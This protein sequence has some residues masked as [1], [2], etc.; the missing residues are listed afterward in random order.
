MLGQL[1]TGA[2]RV[3]DRSPASRSGRRDAAKLIGAPKGDRPDV[4]DGVTN[5]L[6]TNVC[7]WRIM[8]KKSFL[9]DE[10]IFLGPLVRCSCGDVRDHIGSH[11]NDHRPS[12]RSY[13]ALQRRRLLKSDIREI[14]GVARFSTF[15][16]VSAQSGHSLKRRRQLSARTRPLVRPGPAGISVVAT[17]NGYPRD[18]CFSAVVL[19]LLVPASR[20]TISHTNRQGSLPRW[21]TCVPLAQCHGR[22]RWP[23]PEAGPSREQAA[24]SDNDEAHGHEADTGR[25]SPP[26][27]NR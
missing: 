5:R 14:F 19:C 27:E 4:R 9:T 7:F 18:L 20:R 17:V 16:T 15:A 26:S 2:P 8:L 3:P 10:R 1:Q 6:G 22:T 21:R 11:K 12:Y 13:R 23:L 25:H 24:G